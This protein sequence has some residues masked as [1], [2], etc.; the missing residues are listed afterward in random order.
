MADSS[1][2]SA[3]GDQLSTAQIVEAMIANRAVGVELRERTDALTKRLLL[4]TPGGVGDTQLDLLYTEGRYAPECSVS[5]IS[6][7]SELVQR[8]CPQ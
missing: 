1:G 2:V 3:R 5:R 8:S 7:R 4:G 6:R